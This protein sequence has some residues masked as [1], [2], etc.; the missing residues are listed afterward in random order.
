MARGAGG[1]GAGRRA[2][3]AAAERRRVHHLHP[4]QPRRR[5][6]LHPQFVCGASACG[7][8]RR[9]GDWPSAPA[10][11]ATSVLSLA[12]L[13]APP[14]SREHTL[15]TSLFGDAWAEGRDLDLATLIQQVQTPPFAKVGVV[16]LE[17]FFPAK[18]RFDL[19]MQLNGLLAAPGLC[20]VARGRAARPGQ[21]ALFTARASR[22]SRCSRSRTSATPSGCSSSRCCSIR[23][24]RGC[25]GRPGRRACGRWSTWTRSSATFR[26]S[27]I[28]RRRRR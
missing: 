10:S 19:A 15:V 11:T 26:R 8:R 4:G 1:V 24:W 9:R 6:R 2:H 14:R 12:G 21:P 17:A 23:S 25:G 18:D 16:D 13:D 7:A 22:G 5:P 3:R 28:R 27:R 20:A